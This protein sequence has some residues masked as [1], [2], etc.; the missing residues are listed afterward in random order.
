MT[1]E[2]SR[3]AR[4]AFGMAL[5]L[6]MWPGPAAAQATQATPL[7]APESRRPGPPL[8]VSTAGGVIQVQELR[9]HVVLVDFM[10][11]VCPACKQ[12]SV[13]IQNVYKELGAKGFRVLGVALDAD[14]PAALAPY[15]QAFGL[16][17][18]I[19]TAPR[20]D[21]VA[22]VRHPANRP[23]LVPTLVLLD[24]QGRFS[25]LDVGWTGEKVLRARVLELLA[26]PQPRRPKATGP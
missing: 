3:L 21:I 6:I 14:A 22:Y 7:P 4:A 26:E 11:T 17:F 23:F 1:P 5:V 24:R 12:A 13:G 19:G 18:P 8:A 15:A 25:A 9:G 20:A 16:T 10:T 2:A